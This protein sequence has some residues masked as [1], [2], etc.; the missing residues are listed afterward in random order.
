MADD[1]CT[2]DGCER[3]VRVKSRKLCIWCYEQRPDGPQCEAPG[4]ERRGQL[5]K[6][7]C[8]RCRL[9]LKNN[10]DPTVSRMRHGEA[11]AELVAAAVATSSDCIFFG[12]GDYRPVAYLNGRT[13]AASRATWILANGD[14]G[15]LHV[16]HTCHRGDRGCVNIQ[17]LYL[18]DHERNMLD[19][20]EAGRCHDVAGEANPRARFTEDQVLEIRAL[21]DSGELGISA[22]ARR[23]NAPISTINSIV[24][25]QNWAY[26]R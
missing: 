4:C 21:F 12:R 15:D 5:R 7:L 13:M 16:L 2:T 3:K 14:P 17:H 23:F 11:H 26:L 25:R 6:G 22:L 9:R 1:T 18:G 20:V 8:N 24:K 10:G 19:K